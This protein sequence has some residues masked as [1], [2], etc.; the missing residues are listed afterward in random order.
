MVNFVFHS[1]VLHTINIVCG[2]LNFFCRVIL[3][4][5]YQNT[6]YL[7]SKGITT[8][9]CYCIM[10]SEQIHGTKN[11][12]C[13]HQNTYQLTDDCFSPCNHLHS[14]EQCCKHQQNSSQ[15]CHQLRRNHSQS[16][17]KCNKNKSHKNLNPNQ[18]FSGNTKGFIDTFPSSFS[19]AHLFFTIC[20]LHFSFSLF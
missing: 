7:F 16:P 17:Y 18:N 14:K 9:I 19:R 15:S 2:I 20:V 1:T 10:G 11:K 5:S 13:R 4:Y 12:N 8:D 3:Q 6:V